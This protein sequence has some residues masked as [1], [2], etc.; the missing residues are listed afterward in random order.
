MSK[1]A[2]NDTIEESIDIDAA[3]TQALDGVDLG[4]D[5]TQ[6]TAGTGQPAAAGDTD[7]SQYVEGA[8][9]APEDGEEKEIA[10][11]EGK[12]EEEPLSIE[13]RLDDLAEITIAN[14]ELL[15]A[16]LTILETLYGS[17]DTI[18]SQVIGAV[19]TALQYSAVKAPPAPKPA[20][21]GTVEQEEAPEKGPSEAELA[22]LQTITALK[23]RRS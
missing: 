12:T 11:G 13:E 1:D 17:V 3:I 19:Q 8:Q 6:E 18:G 10:A 21:A 16:I 15:K 22:N 5:P 4:E 23:E 14:Q 9:D 7:I 20:P 2:G